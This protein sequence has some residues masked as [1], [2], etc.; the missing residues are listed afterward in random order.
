[1]AP[2]GSGWARTLPGFPRRLSALTA[3]TS[4]QVEMKWYMGGITGDEFEAVARMKRGQLDG[5]GLSIGCEQLSPSLRALRVVGMIQS[6]EESTY[7]LTRLKPRVDQ[8]MAQ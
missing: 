2:E 6:R 3:L 8:E 7:V 4:G 5:A 1:M